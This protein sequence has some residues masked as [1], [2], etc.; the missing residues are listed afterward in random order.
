MKRTPTPAPRAPATAAGRAWLQ[1]KCACGAGAA[2]ATG[3]CSACE[4]RKTLGLQPKLAVSTPGDHWERE[5][6]AAAERVLAG[7]G[8]PALTPLG[9]AP[10]QRDE[11]DK[12][13]EPPSPLGEGLATVGKNL[14]ENNPAFSQFTTR[15][16]D[17]FLAQPA[18]ISVGVPVFFGASYAFLWGMALADPAMRRSFDD[19]N[20][21]MLPGLVP[22][23]PVKTFQYRILDGAQTRFAFDFG[24]DA[25]KLMEA[26][27]GGVLNTQVSSLK[28]DTGGTLDTN[29]P[30]TL[31]LSALQVQMGLFGDGVTLAGGFRNGI[32]PYPLVGQ[33]GSRVMAQTPALPD[34]YANQR[35]VRFTLQLDL[36][37]LYQ[38]FNPSTPSG[39][40][41][42]QREAADTTPVAEPGAGTAV[43]SALA[44]AGAPLDA[45]TRGFMESRF[46]HDFAR[47]RIHAD[48]D[49][50]ASARA[51]SAHAYTV[52][53]DIAFATGRY[54]P[55]TAD[56]RRLLAHELAHVVQQRGGSPLVQR[57]DD[58]AA[59]KK[60]EAER[61]RAQQRLDDW[62]QQ[63][64]PKP[65]TD[66]KDRAFAFTAQD[67]AF[68]ITHDKGMSL[69]DK[70][71]DAAAQAKWAA[72]FRD[73]YQLARMILDSSGTDQR[74][75]RAGMIATDLAT[76]GFTTEAMAL[77]PRLPA[78]QQDFIYTE[79]AQH[80]ASASADQLRTVSAYSAKAHKTPGEHLLLRRLTDRSGDYAK[81]LGKDKLLAALA[82]TLA[83]YK[84]DADYAVAIAEILVFHKDGR[85]PIS[86]WLWKDDKHFLFTV[87]QTPYFVEPGYDGGEQ[88]AEAG[89]TTQGRALTMAADMPWVYTYKQKYYVDLLVALG[90]KHKIAIPAPASL[91]FAS[92]RTWLEAQTGNIGQ[93]LAAE[94]PQAPEQITQAYARIADIFFF[95]V[96]RGD[97]V[98]D[99]AGHI[100]GQAAA[101]PSSMR[102]KSDCD[103]LAT[104]AVRL[105][106]S[107]GF[108]PVGYMA[109][110]PGGK[111]PGHAVALLKKAQPTAPAAEGQ[112]P[113]A[114]VDRYYIVNNKRVTPFDGPNKEAAIR[115]L[116]ANGLATYGAEPESYRVYYEDAA[117]DGAMT[118]TLWTTQDSV[119][120]ADLGKDPPAATAP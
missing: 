73:A 36:V 71:K 69:L 108:T 96:D 120:R 74:D 14:G 41:R 39:P 81:A 110:I 90:A 118:R 11:D 22:Q 31:S 27:N 5:A 61:A 102:L 72:N 40:E 29:G 93:A 30:K 37:K 105:L 68:K 98:P 49:A 82:P 97:V 104:Y 75:S 25:S 99:L 15:L 66:P 51:V 4:R 16:A 95:H 50:A 56:G 63:Q 26:F 38:H 89:S 52:G 92:L 106:R 111:L 2:A 33:D 17:K 77:A 88:F 7:R 94:Y 116:L 78:E 21:A 64:D 55:H 43:R 85:A 35:D 83:A 19:F 86:E 20:L 42:L 119:K 112:A 57:D 113:T 115:A 117:A 46:G 84:A 44:S 8:R 34:L 109:L 76:A 100:G 48:A 53:Q 45:G 87:L 67:M 91:A 107:G 6:D 79:V 18:P 32:S 103:V 3:R 23:F 70:P 12:K 24:L 10:L 59:R 9:A 1:P 60:Q 13:K 101:D 114:P 58:E 28:F 62:A 65:P 80:A 54:A 47:V